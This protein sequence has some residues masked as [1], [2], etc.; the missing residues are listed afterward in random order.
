VGAC[1]QRRH[2]VGLQARGVLLALLAPLLL[3]SRLGLG[4]LL[5]VL[6]LK[7]VVQLQVQPPAQVLGR[8]L[9]QLGAKLLHWGHQRLVPQPQVQDQPRH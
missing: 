4:L 5:P 3:L 7:P 1:L 8:C 2:Q 6:L 9:S